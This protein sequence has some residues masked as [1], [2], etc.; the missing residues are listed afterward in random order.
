MGTRPLALVTGASTG[1]G[2]ELAKI[3]ACEGFD[4]LLAADT[5]LADAINTCRA[6]GADV[7]AAQ[8]DLSTPGGVEAVLAELKGRPVSVLLANAGHGL[9]HAF[10]DQ[11]WKDI[12]HVIDTNVTGTVYLIHAVAGQMRDSNRGRILVTG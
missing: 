12:R 9:G 4:L 11:S 1:I 5:D 8:A 10:L 3:A 6:L 2:Y 7:T